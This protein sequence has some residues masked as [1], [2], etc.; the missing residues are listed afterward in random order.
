MA[1]PKKHFSWL[2]AIYCLLCVHLPSTLACP[3]VFVKDAKPVATEVAAPKPLPSVEN[4]IAAERNHCLGRRCQGWSSY[5]FSKNASP[6]PV[7]GRYD[8]GC[9]EGVR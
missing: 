2:T 5:G 1:H 9:H 8:G 7:R 6:S 4:D 3:Q